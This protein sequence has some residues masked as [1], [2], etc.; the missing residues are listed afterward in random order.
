MTIKKNNVHVQK[1]LKL[2]SAIATDNNAPFFGMVE[3]LAFAVADE[4][5]TDQR[6]F[7]DLIQSL[8][9]H[10]GVA[11]LAENKLSETWSCGELGKFKC[12]KA[13][14]A[15]MRKLPSLPTMTGLYDIA[16]S[17]RE[18]GSFGKNGDNAGKGLG[19]MWDKARVDAPTTAQLSQAMKLANIVR[20]KGKTE[21]HATFEQV[22]DSMIT[23]LEKFR[24]GYNVTRNGKTVAMPANK[25]THIVDAI[26]SLSKLKAGN[27][28]PLRKANGKKAA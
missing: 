20:N 17:V 5:I 21:K 23:R 18:R 16:C 22:I 15:N 19:K 14:F 10:K 6:D 8:R 25:S 27:V 1:M 9:T 28:V 4:A 2:A 3:S 11:T 24:D 13:L 12:V 7:K 26:A